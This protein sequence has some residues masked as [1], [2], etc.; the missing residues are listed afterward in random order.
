MLKKFILNNGLYKVLGGVLGFFVF[1]PNKFKPYL[2]VLIILFSVFSNPK[3]QQLK[4]FLK[5]VLPIIFLFILYSISLLNSSNI[6]IG[7]TLVG[8][9]SPL[10]I[11]P[12][13]FFYMDEIKR[14][15]LFDFFKKYFILALTLYS[16][17]IFIYLYSLGC[18]SGDSSF[19]YGYSY[20]TNEFYKLNDHPIYISSYF[21]VGLLLIMYSPFKSKVLS[22]FA[23]IIIFSGLIIL[24]RKGSIIAFLICALFYFLSNKKNLIKGFS[25]LIIVSIIFVSFSGIKN[26]FLEVITKSK[27]EKNPETSTG[28]RIIV[29]ENAYNLT[30]NNN[31]FGYGVGDVQSVLNARYLEQGYKRVA[32]GNFNAHNQFLQVGLTIGFVG[33][34]L[35]IGSLIFIIYNFSIKKDKKSISI[36]LLF[37]IILFT[38]SYLERQNGV[39]FFSLIISML[40]FANHEKENFNNRSISSSDFRS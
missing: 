5:R 16:V 24:S 35:F 10:I 20:I 25:F 36:V 38:E 22:V 15:S 4:D 27:T 28:I 29:W 31:F 2:V 9:M 37:I 19:E 1:I 30:F 33:L 7:L 18:F 12:I 17:C 23:L 14:K 26:R 3:K 8:R 21:S 40:T 39:F 34:I 32:D 13:S 11:L 6:D